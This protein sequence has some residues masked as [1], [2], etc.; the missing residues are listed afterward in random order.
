MNVCARRS[1]ADGVTRRT[2]DEDIADVKRRDAPRLAGMML[3]SVG[4]VCAGIHE[5]SQAEPYA[6]IVN[7]LSV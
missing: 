2:A 7:R 3:G 1:P 4:L 6:P 5:S